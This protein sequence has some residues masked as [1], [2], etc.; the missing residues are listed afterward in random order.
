MDPS[1]PE[2][3]LLPEE[4][5]SKTISLEIPA[6]KAAEEKPSAEVPGTKRDRSYKLPLKVKAIQQYTKLELMLD[7]LGKAKKL[8]VNTNTNDNIFNTDDILV[9]IAML[10]ADP[11]A[12]IQKI[13]FFKVKS[14]GHKWEVR[15]SYHQIKDLQRSLS[16]YCF[17]K[18]SV[19]LPHLPL[20]N[21]EDDKL[22]LRMAKHINLLLYL[23]R[24]DEKRYEKIKTFLE[25]SDLRGTEVSCIIKN[26]WAYKRIGGRYKSN[27]LM[28]FMKHNLSCCWRKKWFILTE[29]GIGYTNEF[30]QKQ[31][32]DIMFFDN[33]LR[34]RHGEKYS[35]Q[36]KGIVIFTSSRKLKVKFD[37]DFELIDWYIAIVES[38]SKSPYCK[39]NRYSSF[40]PIS[41]RNLAKSYITAY[42]YYEDVADQL[43][44]AEHEIYITDWWM[45]PEVYLKR[46]IP[47]GV[48]GNPRN[49]KFRLDQ[50][51]KRASE[52][53][54]KISILLY[55]EFEHALPNKSQY[56]QET[57]MN[58][59]L[60]NK[61]IEV[62][63]HPG[64]L[65]FLWSHHEKSVIIDQKIV[66]MGG[67]DLCYGRYDL[68]TFPLCEP[69]DDPSLIYFPGQDYS[70]VRIK[71][72]KEV[73]CFNKTLIDKNSTPRMPWRD[74]AV[75]LRG[76]VTK[77]VTRHFIQYWNFAKSDLEGSNRRNFL[78]KRDF[79]EKPEEQKT[80]YQLVAKARS[81]DLNENLLDV[82][83]G[84]GEAHS[85][86]HS[87]VGSDR[88]S[89]NCKKKDTSLQYELV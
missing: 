52:R 19:H 63:R 26:N 23:F 59:D 35:D 1:E 77:D 64:N 25:A 67:L 70:N 88:Y 48:D 75:Q 13:F 7:L 33:T 51:L 84:I 10:K 8:D 34:I 83:Q 4:R 20:N 14:Q 55:R 65:I 60:V 74:I 30:N 27:K 61:N 79:R 40:C 71:D 38:V 81:K 62:I 56:T 44:A 32:R 86:G 29:E 66:F 45:S 11:K 39:E 87:H 28:Q 47:L 72:F 73:D 46:P 49:T 85:R 68:P 78:I 43:E 6:A 89:V 37:T 9:E 3:P 31:F 15:R 18:K 17:S 12:S 36:V 24:E 50:I 57:L 22:H 41:D 82:D 16:Q 42:Q 21:P 80:K 5:D 53:G 2:S 54:V 58:L 69:G 76:P